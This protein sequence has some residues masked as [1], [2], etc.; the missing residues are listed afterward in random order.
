MAHSITPGVNI[1]FDA[2]GP[3]DPS[4]SYRNI[5][6]QDQFPGLTVTSYQIQR[7]RSDQF[8]RTGT[9]TAS[10]DF[11]DQ[12]G[13]F[14]P[15]S[16]NYAGEVIA[17]PVGIMLDNPT[18]PSSGA[19]TIFLGFVDSVE[20]E[21]DKTQSFNV[22]TFN[23]VDGLDYLANTEL[24][25]DL[26]ISGFPPPE[27]PAYAIPRKGFIYFPETDP[28][29]TFGTVGD[30]INNVLDRAE[31]A[32]PTGSSGNF[33]R[34]VFSG[35]VRAPA[36]SYSV[37]TTALTVIDDLCDAEFPGIA[38]RWV[39]KETPFNDPGQFVFHGRLARF[40]ADSSYEITYYKAGDGAAIAGAPGEYAQIRGL[41]FGRA[42]ADLVNSA[43]FTFQGI[44]DPEIP[45]MLVEDATSI[46]NYGR[47]TK[48][49]DNLR[50]NFSVLTGNDAH[51]ECILFGNYWVT[52]FKDPQT[53]VRQVVFRSL[54][55]EDP[56]AAKLWDLMCG[57]EISDVI[58]LNTLH[59]GT[60][61]FD[62]VDYFVEGINY[63]VTPLN[64]AYPN[65]TLT[66]DL[67]PRAWYDFEWT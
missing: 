36:R 18:D 1:I 63:Q 60:G 7:G 5:T 6:E 58:T 29:G 43:T 23:L 46:I 11:V 35:N 21:V 17:K 61:G 41:T 67:S 22:G 45:E 54:G 66:L 33:S 40:V 38:N 15:T 26:D 8:Q 48:S 59:P 56:R 10:F 37:G 57:V 9:G 34:S 32:W 65:V 62:D 12:M 47:R 53:R 4:N 20:M 25:P 44:T 51:D 49:A 27:T 28:G 50:L 39:S 52:V 13:Y 14:D 30:D 31:V 42:R 19:M 3:F 24:I 16:A 2:P 64:P 55:P